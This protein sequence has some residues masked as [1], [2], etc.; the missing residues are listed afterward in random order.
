MHRKCK[1]N[2]PDLSLLHL[3]PH[4]LHPLQPLRVCTMLPSR[5]PALPPIPNFPSSPLPRLEPSSP[6]CLRLGEVTIYMARTAASQT[7]R[8]LCENVRRE[9]L[10]HLF[11]SISGL[12][13]C[14]DASEASENVERHTFHQELMGCTGQSS[15]CIDSGRQPPL[16]SGSCSPAHLLKHLPPT[17]AV[18]IASFPVT[19]LSPLCIATHVAL[20][21]LLR[22][23]RG[24]A[25][26]HR[27]M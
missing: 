16:A 9:D 11:G 26:G 18:W 21:L 12:V 14:V 8:Y 19:P 6:E 5:H 25:S 7:S 17:T 1:T 15:R 22:V 24:E 27:V 23:G 4:T 3:D 13:R 10:N 2:A 20:A